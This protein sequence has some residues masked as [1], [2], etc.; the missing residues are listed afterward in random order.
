[1]GLFYGWYIVGVAFLGFFV[2][3]GI[4]LYAFGVLIKPMS[5]ELDW[6]RSAMVG[7][8]TLA[9]VAG[10]VVSPWIG[11]LIDR[12]GTRT[13][14]A[15]SATLAGASLLPL[16]WVQSLGQ[17]Y[18]LY[19][20]VN[21][22]ARPGMGGLSGP[23]AVANWFIRKR[24][25]AMGFVAAGVSV[26]GIVFVPLTQWVIEAWGWR[27]AWTVLA[28]ATWG[29]L[30]LPAWVFLR[31]RPEDMGLLPDGG[32]R[33]AGGKE[34]GAIPW[35]LQIEESNWEARAALRTR[36]FWL[37][38]VAWALG[39]MGSSSLFLLQTSSYADR[40][41]T[42]AAAAMVTSVFAFTTLWVKLPW[43]IFAERLHVRLC[44]VAYFVLSVVGAVAQVMVHDVPTALVAAV[45]Y[46]VP[47]GGTVQLSS[48]VWADYFGRQSLGAIR[49][50]TMLFQVSSQA[51]GPLFATG[52]FDFTGSYNLA[53]GVF[54]VTFLAAAL[55]MALAVPPKLA[56]RQVPRVAPA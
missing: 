54:A 18:L 37:V 13:V 48:Q 53:F 56:S 7:A 20:A 38:L 34:Q 23:T 36:A 30:V 1:M 33:G 55:L 24:G 43:G 3:A 5:E 14:M 27:A 19:G 26:G 25:R 45:L 50:Y 46:G 11:R 22:L 41:L 42:P 47:A 2:N 51:G 40:G 10:A 44:C 21:G 15:V 29:L 17:F 52:V 28:M 31:R 8:G 39:S 32:P 12:Y 49:G 35:A 16:S 4:T 9:A 6:P